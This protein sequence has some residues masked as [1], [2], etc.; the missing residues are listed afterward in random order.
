MPALQPIGLALVLRLTYSWW[1]TLSLHLHQVDG[2]A[3]KTNTQGALMTNQKPTTEPHSIMHMR[4]LVPV[5]LRCQT[6]RHPMP[7][8]VTMCSAT[9]TAASAGAAAQPSADP[10]TVLPGWSC[11]A[12]RCS[13]SKLIE[14]LSSLRCKPAAETCLH[15]PTA[16][17]I[18]VFA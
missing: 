3:R 13:D 7:S 1:P 2:E 4:A 8:F 10:H 16:A 17:A 9:G 11:R 5:L 6:L 14:P 18:A 12:C 15:A